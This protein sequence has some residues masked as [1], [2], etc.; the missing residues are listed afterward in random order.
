MLFVMITGFRASVVLTLAA[1]VAAQA[2][3]NPYDAI[4]ERNP[5]GLKPPP[6]PVVETEQTPPAPPIKVVLTGITSMFG[7]NSKRAF[8]EMTEQAAPGKG[9][10]ATPRRAMLSEGEADGE[11]EVLSI[12]I[13]QNI[14][15]IRNGGVETELTFE[16]PKQGG[17]APAANVA[18]NLSAANIAAPAPSQPIIISSSESRG[19]VTMAGGGTAFEGNT[20]GVT[21][22]GGSTPIVAGNFGGLSRFGGVN[23]ALASAGNLGRA[24]GNLG[25]SGANFAGSGASLD[26]SAGLSSIPSRTVRTPLITESKP[27]DVDQQIILMEANR[28]R[29]EQLAEAAAKL[30]KLGPPPMPHTPLTQELYGGGPP[31]LPGR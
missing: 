7:P 30:G 20:A 21:T 23:P 17:S 1:L 24:S 4:V 27:V 13:E 19:G 22:F 8:L 2:R 5:F 15:K 28:I 25:A 10:P 18:V 14:V 26:A 29:N 11:I 9:A 3:T 31:P 6:P 12:N 16:A